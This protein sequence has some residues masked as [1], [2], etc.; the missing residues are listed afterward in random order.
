MQDKVDEVNQEESIQNEVDGTSQGRR[1]LIPQ[2][3]VMQELLVIWRRHVQTSVQ[4][5]DI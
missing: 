3:M 1:Q 5:I 4:N 2:E